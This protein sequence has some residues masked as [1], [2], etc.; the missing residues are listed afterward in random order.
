MNPEVLHPGMTVPRELGEWHWLCA[1][2][3][4]SPTI[5]QWLNGTWHCI[6]ETQ[7]VHPET[8]YKRGWRWLAVAIPPK[9]RE[10]DE[11]RKIPDFGMKTET[12][13]EGTAYPLELTCKYVA[14][15]L[16]FQDLMMAFE[17]AEKEWKEGDSLSANASK[18]KN[19][20]GIHAVL[21]LLLDAIYINN[22]LE[23]TKG[24]L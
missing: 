12:A 7:P 6:G 3:A 9:V 24:S 22:P 11:P 8:M 10:D 4:W 16:V 13:F 14:P 21:T 17:R 1:E 20:R 19:S 18:W 2:R 5:A 23:R 15:G